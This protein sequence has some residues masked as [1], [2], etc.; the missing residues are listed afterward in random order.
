MSEFVTFFFLFS[1]WYPWKKRFF[2]EI[3]LIFWNDFQ[4]LF[5]K[6]KAAKT[7]FIKVTFQSNIL[8]SSPG[9]VSALCS[10]FLDTHFSFDDYEVFLDDF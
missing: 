1:K 6:L 9:N 7:T 3:A 2:S 10:L 8:L 5:I 4:S